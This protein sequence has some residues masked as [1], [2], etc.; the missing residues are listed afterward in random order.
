MTEF[1]VIRVR[2]VPSFASPAVS[3]VFV[4]FLERFELFRFTY[5]FSGSDEFRRELSKF[6]LPY[7]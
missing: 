1:F 2:A 5:V 6:I 3:N 7:F 4:E